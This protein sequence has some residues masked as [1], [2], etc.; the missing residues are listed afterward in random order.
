MSLLHLEF[1]EL[2]L[3]HLF[4]HKLLLTNGKTSKY[5]PFLIEVAAPLEREENKKRKMITNDNISHSCFRYSFTNLILPTVMSHSARPRYQRSKHRPI[6]YPEERS[7]KGVSPS[8]GT[9][10]SL[11]LSSCLS[12]STTMRRSH[13]YF[14]FPFYVMHTRVLHNLL[15]GYGKIQTNLES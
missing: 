5:S 15:L 10:R 13:G 11:F 7:P 6:G 2:L 9:S 3:F 4:V 8:T 12:C 14:I 1:N